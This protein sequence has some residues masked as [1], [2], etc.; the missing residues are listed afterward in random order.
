MEP[1]F[2]ALTESAMKGRLHGWQ[3][4]YVYAKERGVTLEML[5]EHPNP[6]FISGGFVRFLSNSE[7]KDHKRGEAMPAV[8]L[9]VELARPGFEMMESVYLRTVIQ[10]Y[11]TGVVKQPRYKT[12]WN[13]GIMM[14]Y[15]AKG[16]PSEKLTRRQLYGRTTFV[17]M[18][19]GP[20]RPAAQLRL[21]P[22]QERREADGSAIEVCGHSKTD[23]RRG[24]TWSVL[25]RVDI[26]NLC[27]IKLCDL[28][29]ANARRK[30]CTTSI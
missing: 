23:K 24:V 12:I 4:W 15:I 3:L 13:L 6:A 18:T 10:G 11:T 9:I 17:F 29:K 25:R 30:G 7:I 22:D 8:Q 5:R 14:D 26:P 28:C 27:P 20:L 1:Y 16:P 2:E 21:V 19:L